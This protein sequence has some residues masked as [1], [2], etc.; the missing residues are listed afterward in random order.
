MELNICVTLRLPFACTKILLLWTT[1]A[2]MPTNDIFCLRDILLLVPSN[3]F[4]P[5]VVPFYDV[6]SIRCN[7][8]LLG[9]YV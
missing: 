3:T 6:L 1:Y 9:A 8:Q 4:V 5:F 7:C 2:I